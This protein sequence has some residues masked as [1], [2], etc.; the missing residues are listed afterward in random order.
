MAKTPKIAK[1]HILPC[2]SFLSLFLLIFIPIVIISPN[3]AMGLFSIVAFIFTVLFVWVEGLR[4]YLMDKWDK[5]N[6][7]IHWGII[8]VFSLFSLSL[9][10]SLIKDFRF[11]FKVIP[12]ENDK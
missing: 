12:K 1:E 7:L 11:E 10:Y 5:A 8:S 3:F 9:I 4:K 6:K 2:I